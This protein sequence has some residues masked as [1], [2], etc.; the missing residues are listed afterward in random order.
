MALEQKFTTV[1]GITLV[2]GYHKISWASCA[3]PGTTIEV[4]VNTYASEEQRRNGCS[5][6]QTRNF[7]FS[8]E[9]IEDSFLFAHL[10]EKLKELSAFSESKNC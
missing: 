9:K 1:H 3:A 5:P 6:L 8:L 7:T 2:N 4:Q 10:Y